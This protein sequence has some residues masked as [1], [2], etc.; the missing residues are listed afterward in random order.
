MKKILENSGEC[1]GV[2]FEEATDL[3][4]EAAVIGK[5]VDKTESINASESGVQCS[6]R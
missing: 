2:E 6:L 3:D 1:P 5:R 4:P